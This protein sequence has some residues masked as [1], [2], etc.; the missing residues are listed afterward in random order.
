MGNIDALLGMVV[1]GHRNGIGGGSAG[2]GGKLMRGTK[3]DSELNFTL[4]QP[5]SRPPGHQA[6]GTRT[7]RSRGICRRA[8]QRREGGK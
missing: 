5:L 7:S 1:D 3:R 6:T 2:G 8:P 4:T